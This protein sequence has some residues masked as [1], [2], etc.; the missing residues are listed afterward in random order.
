MIDWRPFCVGVQ[1]FRAD[2]SGV[3]VDLGHSRQHRVEVGAGADAFE[4]TGIVARRAIA[5]GVD[6]VVLA[7]WKRNR[8]ATLVGFRR[9]ERGRLVGHSWVPTAGLGSDEFVFYVRSLAAAC[10]LFEFQL[11][12][13]DRE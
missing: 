3:T 2:E 10:D 7:A 13:K 5:A 8:T 9:D 6:D 12:G 4:L 11:T 1:G